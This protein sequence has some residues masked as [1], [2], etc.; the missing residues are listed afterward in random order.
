MSGGERIVTPTRHDGDAAAPA[1][2]ARNG[3]SSSSIGLTCGSAVPPNQKATHRRCGHCGCGY[4][5]VLL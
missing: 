2:V 3:A 1:G 5:A 4:R